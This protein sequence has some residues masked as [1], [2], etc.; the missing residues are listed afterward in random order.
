M[1]IGERQQ[2]ITPNGFGLCVRC[3]CAL[4]CVSA[5]N[6]AKPVLPAGTVNLTGVFN[7]NTKEKF[8]KF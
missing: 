1:S 6:D 3:L 8:L 4:A 2:G 5:S 7:W